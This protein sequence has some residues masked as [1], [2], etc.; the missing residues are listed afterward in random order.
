MNNNKV[1]LLISFILISSIVS[2]LLLTTIGSWTDYICIE[3]KAIIRSA[4]TITDIVLVTIVLCIRN[5]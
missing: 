3:V 5:R 2:C 4:F 1:A